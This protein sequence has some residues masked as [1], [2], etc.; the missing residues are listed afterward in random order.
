MHGTKANM[1]VDKKFLE[2]AGQVHGSHPYVIS[3]P[4][5]CADREQT[6]REEQFVLYCQALR[7]RCLL[8]LWKGLSVII[9]RNSFVT[10]WCCEQ[11]C[12]RTRSCSLVEGLQV[13]SGFPL[14]PSVRG[15]MIN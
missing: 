8:L 15:R 7:R 4:F 1:D 5:A 11:R 13:D 2:T 6:F 3:L 9:L 10:V 14:T 12:L